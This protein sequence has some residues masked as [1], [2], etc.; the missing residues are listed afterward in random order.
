MTKEESIKEIDEAIQAG[1]RALNAL[2]DAQS[3]LSVARGVGVWDILGGGLISGIIKHSKMGAAQ[4][5]MERAERELAVFQRELS[6]VQ[7]NCYNR[8]DF[9]GFSKFADL[10][11]DNFLVDLLIQSRI[12]EVQAGVQDTKQQVQQMI[13]RLQDMRRD[14]ER[15]P[16]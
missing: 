16:K 9:D 6:D 15:T 1:N 13:F 14:V 7:L 2:S 11:F 8:I 12:K 10:L 4:Q 3:N 5:C